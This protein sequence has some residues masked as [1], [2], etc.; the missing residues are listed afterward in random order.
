VPRRGIDDRER[1]HAR[2]RVRFD[3]AG[4]NGR[5]RT[6]GLLRY[7]QDVAWQHSDALGFDRAWY[8]GRGLTWL[9]RAAE[10]GVN[11]DPVI[12]STL[13]VSTEVLGYRKVWA[14]RRSEVRDEVGE[15]R[16]WVS[17][18]WLLIDDI[19]RPTRVPGE[20]G[21]LLQAPVLGEPM[22]RVSLPE[23]PADAVRRRFSV[24]RQELDPLA[25]VNNAV[26]VDWLEEALDAAGPEGREVVA[27]AGRRYRLDYAAA[28]EPAADLETAAWRD[29]PGWAVVIRRGSVELVRAQVDVG[30]E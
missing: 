6:S 26:Y 19:G 9:V 20:I 13:D 1:F 5:L 24:R 22:A 27:A 17:T 3:E 23:L 18:D 7:A 29:G 2:Y 30:A 15:L 4:A 16:A 12:G 21:H 14:R 11:A 28:A 8:R 10:I 25:H